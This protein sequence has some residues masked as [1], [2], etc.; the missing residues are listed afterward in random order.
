MAQSKKGSFVEACVNTAIGF[1]ITLAS[2]P[3]IYSACGVPVSPTKMTA[4][5]AC[6]TAVSVARSYIIR[7]FFN[8]KQKKNEKRKRKRK[9]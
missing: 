4:I 9:I 5:T 8:K 1:L 7:R 2:S 6:F 3:F